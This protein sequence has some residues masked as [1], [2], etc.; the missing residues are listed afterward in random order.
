MPFTTGEMAA[1]MTEPVVQVVVII[2]LE[3]GRHQLIAAGALQVV[4][5]LKPHGPP[6]ELVLPRC[7]ADGLR[8]ARSVPEFRYPLEADTPLAPL[9]ARLRPTRFKQIFKFD[10]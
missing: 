2:D 7:G 3:D 10:S 5:T 4:H 1:S 9:D 8:H 6:A